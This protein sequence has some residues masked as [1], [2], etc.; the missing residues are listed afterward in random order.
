MKRIA[1]AICLC[2]G[3]GISFVVADEMKTDIKFPKDYKTFK[4]YLSM[5][6]SQN[7][8]QIIRIF[9]NDIALKGMKEK[10]VFPYGSVLTAEIYKAKL[11]KDGKVIES[12]LGR[13]IRSKLAVIAVMEKRKGAS[14]KWTGDLNNGDWDFATFNPDGSVAKIDL[15]QCAACHA[16][17]KDTQHVFSFDHF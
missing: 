17:L 5:D 14:E 13:R 15:K 6:Q 4:N 12:S 16:P 9:A 3:M 7:H 2:L 10:G 8:D 1:L 11:D